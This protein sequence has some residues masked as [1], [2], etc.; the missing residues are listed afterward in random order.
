[1]V[2]RSI[3]ERVFKI[4]YLNV[5]GT[6]FTYEYNSKQFCVTAKHIFE[7]GNYPT[8]TK[9]V[10]YKNGN[11][12][13]EKDVII[14]YHTNPKVDIAV[15]EFLDDFTLSLK[16]EINL[17]TNDIYYSQDIFY[18]GYPLG[19]DMSSQALREYPF[20]LVKKGIISAFIN[21]DDITTLLLDGMNNKGFSGGP[22]I[23]EG[24][25]KEMKV[26]GVISGYIPIID[27]LVDKNRNYITSNVFQIQNSGIF[28]AYGSDH[29]F[30]ILNN[31][32]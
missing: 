14:H 28:I 11:D 9:I 26:I 30:E 16:F 24:S 17:G 22:V 23:S 8:N 12:S 25:N 29:I 15:I 4:G 5:Y 31:I 2:N 7:N 20:P 10:F 1:M 21:N 27:P 32:K 13:L 6:A 3:I 18:L 19:L